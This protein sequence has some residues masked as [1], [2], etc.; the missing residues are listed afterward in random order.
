MASGRCVWL[1]PLSHPIGSGL[2]ENRATEV[3][4][5]FDYY[6]GLTLR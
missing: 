1:L 2:F 6:S 5:G 3:A 4:L